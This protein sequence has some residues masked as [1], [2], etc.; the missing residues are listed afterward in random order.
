MDQAS[1]IQERVKHLTMA[2]KKLLKE[3]SKLFFVLCAVID[4]AMEKDERI[5][6]SLVRFSR[7]TLPRKA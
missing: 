2:E 5:R 6:Q 3:E 7:F 1:R 4:A